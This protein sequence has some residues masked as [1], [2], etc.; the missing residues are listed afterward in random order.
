LEVRKSDGY[1]GL[2]LCKIRADK[3]LHFLERSSHAETIL[4]YRRKNRQQKKRGIPEQ[5]WT[6]LAAISEDGL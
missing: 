6:A 2:I 4:Q 3:Y 1:S 5:G